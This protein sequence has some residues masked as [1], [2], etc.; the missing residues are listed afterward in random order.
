MRFNYIFCL[1]LITCSVSA[2]RYTRD[3][4]FE[5]LGPVV[6]P[7]TTS[8]SGSWCPNGMG[9][10]ESLA[11]HPKDG[12]IL[13]A[14]SNSGGLYSSRDGGKHWQFI[15]D[16]HPV[17][18]VLDLVVDELD[19]NR[20]WVGTGTTVNQFPFGLGVLHSRDG[21]QTWET[22][23]L[24]FVPEDEEVIWGLKR[25][26]YDGGTFVALSNDEIYLSRDTCRNF[27][28]LLERV[29][30][31]SR[32]FRQL[33]LPHSRGAYG[34]AAG[35]QIWMG[36]SSL[37]IWQRIDDRLSYHQIAKKGRQA[38]DRFAICRNPFR[39][40]GLLVLYKYDGLNYIDRS[41]DGGKSWTNLYKGR[42]FSRVDRN[43][44]EIA[45]D[46][47]DSSIIY[48]GSVRMYRSD[49]G[50]RNFE[51]VSQPL[52]GFSNFMHDDIRALEFDGQ[53]NLYTG[54]DGG[55]SFSSDK[56]TNWTDI[57]GAG[58]CVTQIYG[59]D[60]HS[61]EKRKLLI[62]CQDLGNFIYDGNWTNLGTVYGDGGVCLFGNGQMYIMQNGHLRSSRG[63]ISRWD[64][65]QMPY[66][67]NRLHYPLVSGVLGAELLVGDDDVLTYSER[68]WYNRSRTLGRHF[69]KIRALSVYESGDTAFAL[70][71][72]DQPTW[73]LDSGLRDR[74]FLGKF[75]EGG[76]TWADITAKLPILA[77]R[78]VSSICRDP[79]DARHIWISLYG[80]DDEY[81]RFKVF[82]SWDGGENWENYSE[83]LPNYGTYVLLPNGGR[84]SGVFLGTDGGLFFRNSKLDQW[85]QINGAMPDMMVRDLA[86]QRQF[87]MLYIATYGNG[88]W[89]LKLPRY[90]RK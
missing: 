47:G 10:I 50:G 41:T 39:E 17:C 42:I 37:K 65:L 30:G 55:V 40:Q 69:T 38:P 22:T 45:Y 20:I 84:K 75:W 48:V 53:G 31:S 61:S 58:L 67:A 68:K 80:Y 60:A 78:S 27:R 88:V 63:D 72:K 89:E 12:S 59:I 25:V 54:N 44:A 76:D 13:Y 56:G 71:A 23:G 64:M 81:G 5:H 49:D 19:P 82:Q 8:D 7:P 35:N 85:V 18:G 62:G 9:W 51:L 73:A 74:L 21:G 6:L 29:P 1:L 24:S 4:K 79:N 77:W 66:S 15:F 16:V 33:L 36:D 14:G 86:M 83:G 46:P 26:Q 90:L 70:I 3:F 52:L 43:H 87:K 2:Q 11:I 57:S 34:Y 32:D 28:K